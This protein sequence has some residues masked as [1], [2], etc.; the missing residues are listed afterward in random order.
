M[1]LLIFPQIQQWLVKSN[2]GQ[3][4]NLKFSRVSVIV[5]IAG[6]LGMGLAVYPPSFI[7]G[8]WILSSLPLTNSYEVFL[9]IF[10]VAVT[11]TQ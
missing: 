11:Y 7:L 9:Y 4:S 2:T 5:L 3:V 1:F 6:M 10:L 8:E